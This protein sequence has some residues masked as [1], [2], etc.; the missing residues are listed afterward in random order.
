MLYFHF[1]VLSTLLVGSVNAHHGAAQSYDVDTLVT[2]EGVVLSVSWRNPHVTMELQRTDEVG[3]SEVWEIEA[4][5]ANRLERIGISRDAVSVGSRVSFTG[6]PSRHGLNALAAWIMTL[7]SGAELPIWPQRARRM[8]RIVNRAPVDTEIVEASTANA[9]G[10][11]RVWS[12]PDISGQLLE[13]GYLPFTEEAL[14]AREDWDPLV[15][16]LVLRCIARG[17]PSIMNNPQPM[18]FVDHGNF[19][20]LRLEEW[21]A[22]RIIHLDQD[23]PPVNQTASGLGYSIGRWEGNILVVSTT[24]INDPYFDDIGTPQGDFSSVEERFT[25]SE[26][27]RRLDYES[28]HIDLDTFTEPARQTGYWDW[29]P[30][31]EVKRYNC[32]VN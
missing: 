22:E 21:D 10:I 3:D 31:E 18:E 20:V 24:H 15:D 6:A 26:D 16:D 27:E 2:I 5:T 19:I 32:T 7:E 9:N 11:F 14:L 17:M 12:R 8:G 1:I 30:G 23:T 25:L 4:S 13:G 29:V 28:I